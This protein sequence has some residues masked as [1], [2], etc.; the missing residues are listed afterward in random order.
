[1]LPD[2]ETPS[3]LTD[4]TVGR[5]IFNYHMPPELRFINKVLDK[6]EL[7]AVVAS[8]YKR[9]GPEMTA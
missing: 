4:T 3:G 9:L 2:E 5:V 6:G 8:A 1:M 7:N